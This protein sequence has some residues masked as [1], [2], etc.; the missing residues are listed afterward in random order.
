MAGGMI[1][2]TYPINAKSIG[3]FEIDAFFVEKYCF[4]NR[5]TNLPI[6]EGSNVTDHVTEEPDTIDIEA[7]IGSTKF[8]TNESPP[9]PDPDL[10]NVDIPDDLKGRILQ[11]YYELLRLKRGRQPVDVVT[12]LS[13]FPDMIIVSFE[14]PR[15][16]ETGAD[17]HFSMRF[18][19]LKIVK[20]EEVEISVAPTPAE[21]DMVGETANLG[22]SGKTQIT[23]P[24]ELKE[25]WRQLYYINGGKAPTE[26]EFFEQWGE[27]PGRERSPVGTAAG[28]SKTSEVR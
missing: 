8:E 19:S 20:S 15:D 1:N 10:S 18:Q 16:V 2:F 28:R 26:E 27:W 13:T 4:A 21:A 25:R 22:L 5:M 17:L 3:G 12:G 14:I 6:E 9:G 24:L 11:S 7:F 23:D